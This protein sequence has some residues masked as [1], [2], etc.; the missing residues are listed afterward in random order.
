MG[1]RINTNVSSLNA[2][3]SLSRATDALNTSFR[4]LS[5][6]QRIATA[7]DDAAGLAISE[8]LRARIRSTEQA[9][10]NAQ[11]GISLV[12]TAEGAMQESNSMLIRMRELAVQANTGTMSAADRDTLQAEFTALVQ[13][14]DRV[15]SATNFNTINLLDGSVSSLTLQVGADTTAGVDTLNVSLTSTTAATLGL[16]ALSIGSTGSATTA[17][18]AIDTAINSI[19]QGRGNLGAVQNRLLGLISNLGV[20][21]ENLSAAESRIRDVDIAAET[22]ALTRNTIIQQAAISVLA[23]ANTQPQS[24]LALL[25]G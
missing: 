25:R 18:T 15:A 13:E 8:R 23:Q 4:R 12:Q 22:A 21:V 24:A 17:I 7:A 1:L 11:D 6:G 19:S 3:R 14:I 20:S 10:R 5:T 16:T 9:S 2:Q